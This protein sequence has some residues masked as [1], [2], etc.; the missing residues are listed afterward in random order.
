M[1]TPLISIIVPVYNKEKD[2]GAF[3]ES[4]IS[5]T[6]THWELILVDDGSTDRSAI[7]CDE[8][9]HINKRIHVFHHQFNGGISKARNTGILH[10]NGEWLF[11][12]DADDTLIQDGL[13]F[14]V[15]C[16]SDDIDLVSASYLRYINGVLQPETRKSSSLK[17]SIRD[18]VE[19]IGIIPQSRNLDR[20]VWNK[21]FKTAIIKDNTLFFDDDLRLYEDVCFIYRYLKCCHNYVQCAE[22]PVYSYFRRTEGTAMSSRNHYNTRTFSWLLAYSRIITIV[23]AMDVSVLAKIRVKDEFYGIYHRL[24]NLIHKEERAAEEERTIQALLDIS[25]HYYERVFYG[26]RYY[27]KVVAKKMKSLIHSCFPFE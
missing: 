11:I 3:V 17:L 19:C 13:S 23:D 10:S 2:I 12:S 15:G 5:Q 1:A 22:K 20:Y 14:L 16:I 24:I 18:Y 8:Y 27:S 4:I 6:Y 9:S 26:F 25:F 21:L 7:I